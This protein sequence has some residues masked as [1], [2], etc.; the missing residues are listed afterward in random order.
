M[1]HFLIHPGFHK[2]GTTSLQGFLNKNRNTFAKQD[3]SIFL[4]P[5]LGPLSLAGRRYGRNPGQNTMR[6]F[7]R[8]VLRFLENVNESD[9]VIVSRESLSG[10]MIGDIRDDGSVVTSYAPSATPLLWFFVKAAR[11][12]FGHDTPITMLFTTRNRDSLLR[13]A[14][15]HNL[16]NRRVI[17]TFDD[18]QNRFDPTFNLDD[19]ITK[20]GAALKNVNIVSRTLEEL[21]EAQFGPGSAIVDLLDLPPDVLK[22]LKQTRPQRLGQSD[23]LSA[24][25][26]ELNLTVQDDADLIEQKRTLLQT[27][28]GIRPD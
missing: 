20:I 24:E 23:D 10:R 14:Y 13:S 22:K 11:N 27:A 18:F 17:D 25:L 15:K 8:S 19:E 3:I 28:E 7:K 9:T 1:T 2:T 5:Q 12:K 4:G 16:R 6:K 26:L 21:I